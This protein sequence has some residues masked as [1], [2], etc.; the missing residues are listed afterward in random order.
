MEN[1]TTVRGLNGILYD[2]SC[3]GDIGKYPDG[4]AMVLG[5]T[6]DGFELL[7]PCVGAQAD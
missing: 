3:E 2:V 7:E 5:V 1:P 4:N 6:P